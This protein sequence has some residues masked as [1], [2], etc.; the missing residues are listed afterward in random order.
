MS[1]KVIIKKR[2]TD[3]GEIKKRVTNVGVLRSIFNQSWVSGQC[4][5][6]IRFWYYYTRY[7][8]YTQVK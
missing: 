1:F 6:Q 3:V 7:V 5:D 2:V 4:I 8:Y